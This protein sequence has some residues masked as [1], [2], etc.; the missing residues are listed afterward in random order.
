MGLLQS[1]R[2]RQVP[3]ESPPLT[4]GQNSR[5]SLG[6]SSLLIKLQGNPQGPQVGRKPQGDFDSSISAAQGRDDRKVTTLEP[7]VGW[8][9]R[10]TPGEGFQQ[11]PPGILPALSAYSG[12]TSLKYSQGQS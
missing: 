3:S 12:E 5:E 2:S 9:W 7:S 4:A 8:R 10:E 6:E 11:E 1:S